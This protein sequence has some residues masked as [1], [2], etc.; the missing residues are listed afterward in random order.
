MDLTNENLAPYGYQARGL[1]NHSPSFDWDI[2]FYE[3]AKPLANG[4]IEFTRDNLLKKDLD[5]E[6]A[7]MLLRLWLAKNGNQI[8]GDYLYTPE[9]LVKIIF[10]AKDQ[11]NHGEDSGLVKGEINL[12]DSYLAYLF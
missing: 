12:N 4:I 5:L 9:S 8:N 2:K 6:N 11:L 1:Y 7:I 3:E 10:D